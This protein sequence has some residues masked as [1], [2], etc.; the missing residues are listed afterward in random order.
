MDNKYVIIIIINNIE[1]EVCLCIDVIIFIH[2]SN[3]LYL[4]IKAF[5]L[6]HQELVFNQ[7]N[8]SLLRTLLR[9]NIF[10]ITNILL[11][12]L[13]KLKFKQNNKNGFIIIIYF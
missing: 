3:N 12:L 6:Q 1:N 11:Y 9:F 10:K 7:Y 13:D 2:E 8:H 4:F 5:N